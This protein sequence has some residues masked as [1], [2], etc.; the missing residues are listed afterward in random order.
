MVALVWLEVFVD[1]FCLNVYNFSSFS[2]ILIPAR[3]VNLIRLSLE[4]YGY[5]CKSKESIFRIHILSSSWHNMFSTWGKIC[6]FL[7][8]SSGIWTISVINGKF[9]LRCEGQWI[10]G[11]SYP[12][13]NW[14]TWISHLF[15]ISF[16]LWKQEELARLRL[17]ASSRPLILWFYF[18]GTLTFLLYMQQIFIDFLLYALH[19]DQRWMRCYI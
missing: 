9:M 5:L 2:V 14:I 6:R 17:K 1:L 11:Q 16:I 3:Q 18:I 4:D 8:E 15:R 13:V 19:W 7:G 12:V 10:K